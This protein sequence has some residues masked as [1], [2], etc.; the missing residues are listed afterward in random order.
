MTTET[1]K[2]WGRNREIIVNPFAEM[3][4]IFVRPSSYCSIHQHR[5]KSNLFYCLKGAIVVKV[6]KSNGLIDETLLV[7]GKSTSVG[8]GEKHQFLTPK[9]ADIK[10]LDTSFQDNDSVE[11]I[12][13]YYPNPIN[14]ADIERE[15]QGGSLYS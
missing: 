11:V 9:L 10:D 6:W 4:H 5:F 1:G 2:V 8:P 7:P 3:H 15:T 13:L 14:Q 12:E